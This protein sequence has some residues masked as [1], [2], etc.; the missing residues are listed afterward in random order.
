VE[1]EDLM[2]TSNLVL[3]LANKAFSAAYI[4]NKAKTAKNSEPNT[5]KQALRYPKK[6]EWLEASFKELR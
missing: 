3:H 1:N 4:A 2:D 6:E 5:F